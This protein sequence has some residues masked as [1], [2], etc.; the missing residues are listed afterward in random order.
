MN[1]NGR[2]IAPLRV[3]R[4][5]PAPEP[6]SPQLDTEEDELNRQEQELEQKRSTAFGSLQ[7]SGMTNVIFFC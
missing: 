7:L 6:V 5:E 2:R 3:T 4:N 1:N